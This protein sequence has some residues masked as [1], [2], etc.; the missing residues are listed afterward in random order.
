MAPA[1]TLGAKR[2]GRSHEGPRPWM[3]LGLFSIR[4]LCVQSVRME[5]KDVNPPARSSAIASENETL[6]S[7]HDARRTPCLRLRVVWGKDLFYQLYQCVAG[8]WSRN[9]R[10]PESR[11]PYSQAYGPRPALPTR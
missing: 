1:D 10:Q 9:P 5:N 4:T 2:I 8:A 11:K 6:G 7:A 3:R